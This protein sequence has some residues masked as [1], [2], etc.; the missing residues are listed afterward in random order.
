MNVR[1]EHGDK[2]VDGDCEGGDARQ[3]SRK[4]GAATCATPL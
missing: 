1:H 2:R 4:E 3:E